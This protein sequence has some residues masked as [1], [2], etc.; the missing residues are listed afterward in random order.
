MKENGTKNNDQ[1]KMKTQTTY[2]SVANTLLFPK[3][4]DNNENT[5]KEMSNYG[6]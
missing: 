1:T 5:G 3:P 6:I 2:R 4:H